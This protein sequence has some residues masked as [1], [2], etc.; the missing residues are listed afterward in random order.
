MRVNTNV[1]KYVNRRYVINAVKSQGDIE[2]KYDAEEI[3]RRNKIK[4]VCLN[5]TKAK[6]NGSQRCFN[7]ERKK[8]DQD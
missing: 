8:H 3:E 1:S 5:C 7:S 2:Q 6:C 4:D